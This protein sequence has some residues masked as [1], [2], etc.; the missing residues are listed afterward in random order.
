MKSEQDSFRPMTRHACARGFG[1]ADIEKKTP[2]TPAT[3]IFQ[4]ERAEVG[5]ELAPD[6]FALESSTESRRGK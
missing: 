3:T 2:V 5:V 6:T 4:V 1:V